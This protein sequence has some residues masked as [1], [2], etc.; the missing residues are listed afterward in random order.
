MEDHQ[1]YDRVMINAQLP[2]QL[3]FY[4]VCEH[5][6]QFL[7]GESETLAVGAVHDQDDNLKEPQHTME[8]GN[9]I[10]IN[11][12]LTFSES[13][14]SVVRIAQEICYRPPHTHTHIYIYIYICKT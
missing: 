11:R 10:A 2:T 9:S 6:V 3:D 1:G 13:V 7:L 4:L 14:L 12:R 5:L 8:S